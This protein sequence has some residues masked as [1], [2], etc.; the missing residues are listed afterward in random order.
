MKIISKTALLIV[1]LALVLFYYADKKSV[2][3]QTLQY[4]NFKP[5]KMVFM[6]DLHLSLDQKDDWIL[7]KESLVI[8]QDVMKSVKKDKELDFIVLGGDLLDNSDRQ[9]TDMP[10]LLDILSEIDKKYYVIPGDRDVNLVD[11]YNKS[12][13][14]D[15]FIS[16]MGKTYWAVEPVDNV[17]LIGLDTTVVNEPSGLISSDQI[18][19]L[20][21][22]LA[23]NKNKFTVITMH[24]P[25]FTGA[26][27]EEKSAWKGLNIGNTKEFLDI[28]VKYPQI[29]L[30][31]S[32]HSHIAYSKQVNGTVFVSSPSIVTYPNRYSVLT[33]YPDKVKVD[34]VSISFKQI[35]KKA[36]VLYD[37]DKGFM[38]SSNCNKK[39]FVGSCSGGKPSV[40]LFFK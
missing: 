1:I 11:G 25:A 32:G 12:D 28:I 22:T 38:T 13:F 21:K 19:W 31:L 37:T 8:F 27:N 2:L 26:N 6:P 4:N 10:M 7:R 3:A 29:K 9:L 15:E 14:L 18:V 33:V 30:V 34:N 24:H 35:I 39:K 20:D 5:F 17:L 36:K 16:D 23:E 40:Y